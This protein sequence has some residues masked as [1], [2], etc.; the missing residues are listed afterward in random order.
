[1][2]GIGKSGL[3]R[4]IGDAAPAG[5][6]LGQQGESSLEPQLVHVSGERRARF[7]QQPLQV[8]RRD[9]LSVRHRG[10][11]E[12]GFGEVLCNMGE[13]RSQ[14]RRRDCAQAALACIPVCAER[15]CDEVVNVADGGLAQLRRSES[16]TSSR[17]SVMM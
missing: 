12:S 13:R 10:Q 3:Q 16:D 2:R 14:P 15:Q 9:T 1:M 4:D 7:L 6:R 17:T 8:T 11:R 5:M